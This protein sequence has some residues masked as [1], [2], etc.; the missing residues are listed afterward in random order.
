MLA[1][2][3]ELWC[4]SDGRFCRRSGTGAA[5]LGPIPALQQALRIELG[6]SARELVPA[7]PLLALLAAVACPKAL[8]AVISD[9]DFAAASITIIAR[10]RPEIIRFRMGKWRALGWVP[11]GCSEIKTPCSQMD[12]INCVFSVG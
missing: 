2:N 9:P 12:R 3:K 7:S 4:E 10:L 6:A 11:K 8:R 1:S 5:S